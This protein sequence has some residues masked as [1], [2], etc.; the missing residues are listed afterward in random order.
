[1]KL[2]PVKIF[3]PIV[4]VLI[5]YFGIYKSIV[6][7]PDEN[8]SD[9]LAFGE[10][11][12][13]QRHTLRGLRKKFDDSKTSSDWEFLKQYSN[14]E[15]WGNKFKSA[16]ASLVEVELLNQEVILDILDEDH[17]D[18]LTELVDSL[19][20]GRLKLKLSIRDSKFSGERAKQL[21]LGRDNKGAYFKS[22]EYWLSE[23]KKKA[24]ILSKQAKKSIKTHVVKTKDIYQK[25]GGLDSILENIKAVFVILKNEYT[26]ADTDYAIYVDSYA[27]LKNYQLDL[28]KFVTN[29]SG[30]LKQLD[31]SYVKVLKDQ[32]AS[33]SVT[34]GR[35]NWCESDHCYEGSEM[36]YPSTRVDED[37]FE[38]FDNLNI[39]TI[40]KN[41]AGVFGRGFNLFIPQNRWDALNIDPKFRWS[42]GEP[43]AEYWVEFVTAKT[44]HKYTVLTNGEVREHDWVS[45]SNEIYWK[46][47]E[48]LGMAI[49]TKPLGAYDSETITDAEP[50]GMAAIA[51]PTMKD[52]IPTGSN[53]YGEW[54]H[55]GGSSYWHYYGMYRFFGDFVTP[56][57]YRYND[58]S[59]YSAKGRKG[60]YYG[61]NDE[62]GT[63][64]YST[65]EHD[66]YKS[67]EYS[68][69][70]P[71][72]VAEAKTGKGSDV[73]GSIRG[74]GPSGRGKGPS[75][76]GK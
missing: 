76:S 24:S 10:A 59:G 13:R 72:T 8:V 56:G 52:G 36:R 28:T 33:Y 61:Q 41:S 18:R 38:Y 17:K 16:A 49:L 44:W 68:R 15:N 45:V 67:S 53:H 5:A 63:W 39:E 51:T 32:M 6:S 30:L 19:K 74:A 14:S 4:V 55:S 65:Y 29:N 23:S 20:V 3:I 37:T 64:G 69:R 25:L 1:M 2:D 62:Y 42:N 27:E 43:Y 12:E 54:R 22:S 71:K 70:N 75:G 11:V 58:W 50:V 48:H 9:A 34:I 47:E 7:L 57:R 66:K 31:S 73:G 21:I 46:H 35:A 60:A 26:A 40:A